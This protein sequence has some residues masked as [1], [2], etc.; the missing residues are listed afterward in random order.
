MVLAT[1][2]MNYVPTNDLVNVSK[3]WKPGRSLAMKQKDDEARVVLRKLFLV[4]RSRALSEKVNRG[5]GMNCITQQQS[6]LRSRR[7]PEFAMS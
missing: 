7:W 5:A 2:Y 1:S 4:A 6:A 3:V